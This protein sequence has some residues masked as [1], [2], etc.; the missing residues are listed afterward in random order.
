ME[1]SSKM[2]QMMK[3][4]LVPPGTLLQQYLRTRSFQTKQN[5]IFINQIINKRTKL[6][7]AQARMNEHLQKMENYIQRLDAKQKQVDSLIRLHER[8]LEMEFLENLDG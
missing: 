3:S 2:P 8:E 1:L 5:Q 4:L 7:V 6:A